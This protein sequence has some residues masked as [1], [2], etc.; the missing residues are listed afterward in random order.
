[1]HNDNITLWVVGD[2]TV[3]AFDD[4]YYMPRYG[5]GCALSYYFN[6]N[7]KIEN[8]AI[9]GIS[10]KSFR[11]REQYKTLLSGMKQG[12]YLIIGFGHNDEKRGD[13]TFTSGNGDLNTEGSFANSLYTYYIREARKRGTECVLVTPIVRRSEAGDYAG[14]AVHVTADGD[15]AQAVRKL[16]EDA[17]VPVCD[18][19]EETKELSIKLGK[20]V[21][22]L[23]ART[24]SRELCTDNTHTSL[25]GAAVNAYL[26]AEDIKKNGSGLAD[27]LRPDYENPF[28][29]CEEW[30][31]RSVNKDYKD[32]VYMAPKNGS[33]IWPDYKDSDGNIWHGTVFGDISFD[34][35]TASQN[36]SLE[37]AEDGAMVIAAGKNKNNGKIMDKSD[38]LAMYF[39]RL[40]AGASF[41]LSADVIPYSY[42]TAGDHADYSA[43]GAM[44][45]D[46]MYIDAENG[47]IMGDYIAAGVTFRPGYE[48]GSNTF[49]RKSGLLYFGGGALA[50]TPVTGKSLHV[51][52]ASTGD[53]YSAKVGDNDPVIAGYDYTLNAVDHKYIY[54]GFFAARTVGIYVKNIKM[55]PDAL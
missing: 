16:G 50:H 33:S 27:Y 42:F 41:K 35:A 25:F 46:D 7:V 8:L 31:E 9:S 49:A 29:H 10:S 15:Y 39:M 34:A 28:D 13:V 40:P 11:S 37:T 4:N 44:V 17:N 18:L 32:P 54:V 48:N 6:E 26:I 38:G 12:D 51:E 21:I 36:F 1:M 55:V 52:I 23:H 30:K 45:R 3:S 14:A 5:W 47:L 43:F 24:G 53:G 22:F 2:S 20:E 19:T